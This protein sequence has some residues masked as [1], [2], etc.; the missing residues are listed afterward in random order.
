[1]PLG[2]DY[3]PLYPPPRMDGGT[4]SSQSFL[5]GQGPGVQSFGGSVV[6]GP[7]TT[8]TQNPPPQS[9][10]NPNP[11]PMYGQG[12][13]SPDYGQNWN[14]DSGLTYEQ[15]KAN[16]KAWRSTFQPGG[17]RYDR[18]QG[19][20]AQIYGKRP[21]SRQQLIDLMASMGIFDVKD[22]RKHRYNEI[23]DMWDGPTRIGNYQVSG[24]QKFNFGTS[25]K[26]AQ[27]EPL[28][29]ND[30]KELG[31]GFY[32]N[33]AGQLGVGSVQN[34]LRR[35]GAGF[36]RDPATGFWV[37]TKPDGSKE[38][39]RNDGVKVDA[40]GRPIGFYGLSGTF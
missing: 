9:N 6:S 10:P 21:Q 34:W 33:I 5:P 3:E 17:W 20:L 24:G 25:D 2:S 8:P 27:W 18:N 28:N 22:Q 30:I 4:P 36:T 19:E 39:V 16:R 11:N 15:Y 13:D 12:A 1:M 38:Y 40:N 26:N 31:T 35:G 37:N 29:A 23:L 14:P 32:D 7:V